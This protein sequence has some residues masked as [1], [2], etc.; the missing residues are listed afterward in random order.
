MNAQPGDPNVTQSQFEKLWDNPPLNAYP[1]NARFSLVQTYEILYD[2]LPDG[3]PTTTINNLNSITITVYNL[4][5]Y[6]FTSNQL[7][8]WPDYNIVDTLYLPDPPETLYVT[9]IFFD[10]DFV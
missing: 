7:T 10:Q 8:V 5:N 2:T 6:P 1:A 3:T 9:F 4:N